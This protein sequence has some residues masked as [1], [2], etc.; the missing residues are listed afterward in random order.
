MGTSIK[1]IVGVV[2]VY[3]TTLYLIG[4]RKG[5][6]EGCKK[7]TEDFIFEKLSEHDQRIKDLEENYK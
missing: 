4:H 2:V 5:Y 3:C 7:G 6:K 1:V